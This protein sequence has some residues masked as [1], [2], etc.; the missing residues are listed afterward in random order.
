[1]GPQNAQSAAWNLVSRI[2]WL[3]TCFLYCL[4]KSLKPKKKVQITLE[5]AAW[6]NPFKQAKYTKMFC[7]QLIFKNT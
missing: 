5:T 2:I 7:N 3:N 4:S 1:M 6:S